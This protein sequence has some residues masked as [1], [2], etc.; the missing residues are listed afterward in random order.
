MTLGIFEDYN[1]EHHSSGHVSSNYRNLNLSVV[2]YYC[3][4]YKRNAK[5]Y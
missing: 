2:T 4:K 1:R 5:K 3:V